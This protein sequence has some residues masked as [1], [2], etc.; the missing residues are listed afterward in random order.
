M[1]KLIF[2]LFSAVLLFAGAEKQ[3]FEKLFTQLFQKKT[4]LIYTNNK[5]KKIIDGSIH[6]IVIDKCKYADIQFGVYDKNCSK[7]VFVLDYYKYKK[8]PD[9]LGAFYWRK[10]R[11]QLRL[12]KKI[13]KKYHLH[14]AKDFEDYVE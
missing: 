3:L 4:I 12:R 1:K 13:I 9:V 8:N 5:Y 7:P 11:P 14:I 2:I 6:L 10:G